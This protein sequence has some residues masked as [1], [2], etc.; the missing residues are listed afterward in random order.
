MTRRAGIQRLGR[1]YLP[2]LLIQGSRCVL[3]LGPF[4]RANGGSILMFN[5]F[6]DV[7]SNQ[8]ARRLRPFISEF[9][10]EKTD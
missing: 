4:G 7:E 2:A 10:N 5:G 1:L 6:D 9:G 8:A 3:R